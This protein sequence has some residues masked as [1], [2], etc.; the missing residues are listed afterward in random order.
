MRLWDRT[1]TAWMSTVSVAVVLSLSLS[2]CANDA[3]EAGPGN[4]G[5]PANT[6]PERS[7]VE[8]LSAGCAAWRIVP[9]PAEYTDD[10][11]QRAY[12][13]RTVIEKYVPISAEAAVSA[14]EEARMSAD[15]TSE[16]RT[17]LL[18]APA[19]GAGEWSARQCEQW[20]ADEDSAF[21][22]LLGEKWGEALTKAARDEVVSTRHKYPSLVFEPGLLLCVHAAYLAKQSLTSAL[23]EFRA[24]EQGGTAL[25]MLCPQYK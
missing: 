16:M 9:T 25:R 3:I 22:R 4:P 8:F 2:G 19:D 6:S 14:E 21:L 10:L 7:K 17:V 20:A 18:A 1:S 23:T 11:Y 12:A 5:G 13:T 15:L 24:T